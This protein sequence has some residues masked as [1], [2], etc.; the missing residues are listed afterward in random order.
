MEEEELLNQHGNMG[1][2]VI[3]VQHGEHNRWQ[4]KV[5]YMEENRSIYFRSLLE[6][7]KIIEGAL[8][9]VEQAPNEEQKEK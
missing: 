3:R 7:I 4:G 6:L 1:N 9:K 8:D 2:F 5:T